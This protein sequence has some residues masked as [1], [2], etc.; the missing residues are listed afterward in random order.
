M[1]GGGNIRWGLCPLE[2][3]SYI[4]LKNPYKQ[5]LKHIHGSH[6]GKIWGYSPIFLPDISCFSSQGD[7]IIS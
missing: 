2:V 1:S 3:L 6:W 5:V 4:R 7:F